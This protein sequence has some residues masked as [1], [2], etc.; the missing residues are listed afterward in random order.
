MIRA[1]QQCRISPASPLHGASLPDEVER[2]IGE[3]DFDRAVKELLRLRKPID[4]FFDDVMVMVE[5]ERLR[6]M[7]LG[8][9]A[10]VRRL[11]LWIADFARVVLEGEEREEGRA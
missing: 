2:A 4:D 7:R 10:E 11:F 1:T 8:L 3:G 9:L 6:N 5:D